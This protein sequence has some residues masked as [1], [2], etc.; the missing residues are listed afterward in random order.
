MQTKVPSAV[1]TIMMM[2]I[3][4]MMMMMILIKADGDGGL[5][6]GKEWGQLKTDRGGRLAPKRCPKCR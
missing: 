6:E 4:M 3:M 2:M 5:A 1:I